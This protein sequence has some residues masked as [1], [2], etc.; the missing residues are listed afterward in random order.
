MEKL[1]KCI[2]WP[3]NKEHFYKLSL[4]LVKAFGFYCRIDRLMDK[5]QTVGYAV[6]N[7]ELK[8]EI[9]LRPVN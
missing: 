9:T 2:V 7:S 4:Q 1:H 8:T 3:R 6:L 5:C